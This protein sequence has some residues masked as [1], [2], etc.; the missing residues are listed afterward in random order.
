MID[1]LQAGDK[2]LP[3]EHEVA[4]GEGGIIELPTPQPLV[5]N[6]ADQV[7]NGLF[8]RADLPFLLGARGDEFAMLGFGAH[9]SLNRV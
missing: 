3:D 5:D 2:G 1:A 8:A 4:E 9:G 7:F 6:R